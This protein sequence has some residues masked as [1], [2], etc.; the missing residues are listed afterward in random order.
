MLHDIRSIEYNHSCDDGSFDEV[1]H[2]ETESEG[3]EKYQ[4]QSIR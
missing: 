1:L 2:T 4:G 3:G